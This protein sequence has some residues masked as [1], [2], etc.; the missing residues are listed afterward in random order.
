MVDHYDMSVKEYKQFIELVKSKF[1]PIPEEEMQK[2]LL[3]LKE[4][5]RSLKEI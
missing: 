4:E 5:I 3:K 1:K 2:N